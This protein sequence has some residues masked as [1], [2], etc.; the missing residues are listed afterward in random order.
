MFSSPACKPIN[1][2][3]LAADV[4]V[5]AVT[6]AEIAWRGWHA[7]RRGFAAAAAMRQFGQSLE[8]APNITGA[9]SDASDV[10]DRRTN[11]R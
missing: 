5:P 7:F 3:A 10:I 1:L 11:V 9:C 6:K 2:D 8:Y 4:I